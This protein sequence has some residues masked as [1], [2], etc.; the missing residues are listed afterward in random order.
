MLNDEMDRFA[1][2]L[3]AEATK[4][5]GSNYP[6]SR[7][8]EY[9]ATARTLRRLAMRLHRSYE[10]ACNREQTAHELRTERRTEAR[11]LFLCHDLGLAAPTFNGDPRGAPVKIPVAHVAADDWGGEKLL[12]VPFCEAAEYRS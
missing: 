5:L 8:D 2:K 6:V 12:I 9:R 10:I 1:E 4:R 7:R 3:I 11:I